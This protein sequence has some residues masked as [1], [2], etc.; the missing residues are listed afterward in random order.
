MRYVHH[1]QDY[2]QRLRAHRIN[3]WNEVFV[4]NACTSSMDIYMEKNQTI[5]HPVKS[6]FEP[7]LDGMIAGQEA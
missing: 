5:Y 7:L 6:A 1:D 3:S 4:L 2:N